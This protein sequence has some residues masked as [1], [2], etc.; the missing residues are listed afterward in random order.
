MRMHR[1]D[2]YYIC[3]F[4]TYL[5]FLPFTENCLY[6]NHVVKKLIMYGTKT[7]FCFNMNYCELPIYCTEQQ[8]ISAVFSLFVMNTRTNIYTNDF[9]KK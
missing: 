7:H 9:R 8:R 5:Q 4:C 3:G 2:T 6:K 1:T